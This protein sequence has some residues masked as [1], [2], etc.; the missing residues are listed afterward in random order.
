MN[1]EVLEITQT[2]NTD[3]ADYFDLLLGLFDEHAHHKREKGDFF[4][5]LTLEI[6]KNSVFFTERFDFAEV[7][8]WGDFSRAYKV[9]QKKDYGVDLVARTKNGEFFAIQCKCLAQK[10][11]DLDKLKTFLTWG[12]F[13]RNDGGEP[14]EISRRFLFHTCREITKEAWQ[15]LNQKK[16]IPCEIFDYAKLKEMQFDW[17]TA[18]EKRDPKGIANR[19]KLEFQDHQKAAFAEIVRHF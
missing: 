3:N 5:N 15:A 16:G 7:M 4:E 17:K 1:D 6:F 19:K 18:F 14:I 2:E 11:L 8:L 12:E 13:E 10:R 9:E